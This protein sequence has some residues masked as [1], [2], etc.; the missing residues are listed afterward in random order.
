MSSLYHTPIAT[1]ASNAASTW[2]NPMGQLDAAIKN[3]NNRISNIVAAATVD[4]EVQDARAGINNDG[5]NIPAALFDTIKYASQNIFNVMA[6]GA[7]ANGVTD[8][9]T[10]F[11]AAIAD[12]HDAGG[13]VVFI[14]EGTYNFTGW[15]DVPDMHNII[16]RG[17]GPNTVLIFHG[18]APERRVLNF[19]GCTNIIVE[20]L[21]IQHVDLSHDVK[22][23]HAISFYQC[24][25]CHVQDVTVIGIR[26]S[27]F[28]TID[29]GLTAYSIENGGVAMRDCRYCSIFRCHFENCRVAAYLTSDASGATENTH[30]NLVLN[31]TAKNVARFFMLTEAGDYSDDGDPSDEWTLHGTHHNIIAYNRCENAHQA[32]GKIDPGN[33]IFN[34][35]IGNHIVGGGDEVPNANGN[36]DISSSYNAAVNNYFE[37]ENSTANG[38]IYVYGKA[39]HTLIQGNTIVPIGD[40]NAAG[41]YIG[42]D[43]RRVTIVDNTIRGDFNCPGIRTGNNIALVT[44]ANN[45]ISSVTRGITTGSTNVFLLTILGNNIERCT[46]YG[47]YLDGVDQTN[48]VA[49][50]IASTGLNSIRLNG[51]CKHDV[52]VGNTLRNTNWS[53]GT[54]DIG[55][56]DAEKAQINLHNSVNGCSIVANTCLVIDT[57]GTK[58]AG[59]DSITCGSASNVKV[60]GNICEYAITGSGTGFEEDFNV[61]ALA[62]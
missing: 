23:T 18:V 55:A 42:N 2:N 48:I 47:I 61:T 7:T 13:G 17:E 9:I 24:E 16:I 34:L 52:I 4:S 21:K 25:N 26:D 27:V 44:I 59:T 49:N 14:P 37:V 36:L 50:Q 15:V 53:T 11:E 40:N 46:E 5:T 39:W 60:L 43:A 12:A 56:N 38:V 32:F 31:N 8:E 62:P 6:Y 20:R 57:S 35:I 10:A 3:T 19:T 41:I 22:C 45:R 30:H 1:G 28:G 54:T 33:A 29:S 51:T 58:T